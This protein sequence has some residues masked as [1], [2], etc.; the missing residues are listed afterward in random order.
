[1]VSGAL[2]WRITPDNLLQFDASWYHLNHRGAQAFFF[3]NDA[4]TKIPDAPDTSKNYGA[5]YGQLDRTY[6]SFGAKLSSKINDTFSL[7]SAVRYS[8]WQT[9]RFVSMEPV[10]TDN[11][12]NYVQEMM[13]Y[14]GET[15]KPIIQGNLYLDSS[16]DTWAIKHKVTVGYGA[17][18]IENKSRSPGNTFYSFPATYVFNLSNPGYLPDPNVSTDSS[19]PYKKTQETLRQTILLGD[20]VTF[21]EKWSMLAGGT[22]A[23]IHDKKYSNSTGALT[24]DYEKGEFTPSISLMFK[25]I[26]AVT[27][28]ASYMESLEQGPIAPTGTKNVNEQLNPYLSRQYEFGVKSVI[29]GMSLNAAVFRIEKA[30]AYKDPVSKIYSEDGRQVHTGGEMSFSGRVTDNLTL[31]GG[32]TVLDAV[33]KKSSNSTS[34]GKSPQAVPEVIARLYGEYGIPFIKGLT[35]CGGISYTGKQWVNDAN[36]LSIPY[37]LLGDAGARYSHKIFGKNTTFRLN[38]SNV[39]DEH[40]WT[41]MGSDTLNIGSFRTFAFS[42]TVD[43]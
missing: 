15:K 8:E 23:M 7:R 32:L 17:D 33:I 29:G 3:F 14:N 6:M 1:L 25:P 26:P 2:D 42:A 10:L 20:Q 22:Y 21:N 31:L 41:T 36:T 19:S 24:A 12:G 5:P 38:V 9:G 43:L 16:F 37:V 39:T 40:Y 18:H 34:N 13:I 4:V 28:Y 27:I 11:S 30:N 35:L